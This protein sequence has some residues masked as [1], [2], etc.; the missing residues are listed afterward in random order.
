[1]PVRLFVGNLPYNA[2]EAELREHFSAVGPVSYLSLP[3]DRETGQVRG[4]AF[5]EFNDQAQAEAAIR[6][7]NNQSFKGRP[8]SVSIARAREDRPPGG[9]LSRPSAPRLNLNADPGMVRPPA[10][11][12]GRQ[13]REFGPDA[14][15]QTQRNKK[16]PGPKSDRG[17]KGPMREMVRG[18]FFGGE[19][20]TDDFDD[21]VDDFYD[22]PDD[23]YETDD[24]NEKDLEGE[25][26][27]EVNEENLVSRQSDKKG[28][29]D[30]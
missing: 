10:P 19:D 30:K 26:G 21:D 23:L 13:S 20:D 7:F 2:T 6:Q 17:P 22:D 5:I 11:G 3:T 18:Q 16:K 29:D 1:M 27:E 25:S 12:G 8:I 24:L 9:G 14:S 4:F 15:P 28:D